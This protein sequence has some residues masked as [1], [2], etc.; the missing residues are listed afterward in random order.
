MNAE[1]VLVQGTTL[2]RVLRA[3]QN[4]TPSK[5]SLGQFPKDLAERWDEDGL[6]CEAALR[7]GVLKRRSR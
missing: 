2:R 1:A 7:Q 3:E 5:G 6:G 4:M